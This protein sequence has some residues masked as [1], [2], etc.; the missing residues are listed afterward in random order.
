ML[1]IVLFFQTVERTFPIFVHGEGYQI[2][3]SDH[4][5]AMMMRDDMSGKLQSGACAL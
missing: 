1:T 4:C 2:E 3:L 5:V